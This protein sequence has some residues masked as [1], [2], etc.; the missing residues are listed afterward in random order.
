MSDV[1]WSE[2]AKGFIDEWVANHQPD[3]V[4]ED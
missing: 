1:N 3:E 2:L 4:D